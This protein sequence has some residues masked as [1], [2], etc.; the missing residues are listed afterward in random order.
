[1][2]A[3]ILTTVYTAWVPLPV[4]APEQK[5]CKSSALGV[6]AWGKGP[7][8]SLRVKQ[9]SLREAVAELL[10]SEGVQ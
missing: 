3:Q 6:C 7:E 5:I 9:V 1:M 8:T 4:T 10:L 2:C